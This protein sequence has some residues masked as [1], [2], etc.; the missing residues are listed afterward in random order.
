MGKRNDI[1][2]AVRNIKTWSERSEWSDQLAAVFDAHLS[3][4]GE[5]M[6]I[7][8]EDLHQAIVE[9]DY[10]G[11]LFGVMFEDFLSRRLS[12]RNNNIIDDYLERRGW[13]ESVAGR[14][15]L[16]QLRDSVLSIYEAVAVSPGKYC[17]LADLV[18]G[19]KVIRVYEH[20]GT[21]NMVKWDRIAAR[22][23]EMN[24]KHAFS[25]G[26][27]PFPHEASRD[28]LSLLSKLRKQFGKKHTRKR[29]KG[30]KTSLPSSDN[31]DDVLLR[32]ACPAFTSSWLV[33]ILKQSQRPLPAIVTRDGDSLV[34][35]ETRFPFLPEKAE[36]IAARLDAAAE[37]KRDSPQTDAWIWLPEPSTNVE[38]PRDGLA[39]NTSL[40]GQH[41]ISGTL[42]LKPGVL[43]LFTNSVELAERGTDVLEELLHNLIGPA[44]SLLQ[45]PE[46]LMASQPKQDN[47]QQREPTEN[48]DRKIEAEIIHHTLDQH[49]H[50][51]L[52][53]PIPALDNKTPRQCARNKTGRKKVIEWLKHL[54]NNE[55]RRAAEAGQE[56]YDSSWMWKELK[57]T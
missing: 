26:I 38:R 56:P 1:D 29:K 13:R 44:L 45:T 15:Y 5:L 25:G 37:W 11:M 51:C 8:M 17:E 28:L 43:A 10:G 40:E 34:F 55:L 14:R 42:E 2:K 18:R 7:S 30:A 39:F 48:I 33:H 21:Q 22:V 41:P 49:Y 6:D 16:Q 47:D 23:L 3:P 57:L 35:S 36:E 12:P 4:V 24:G 27:L 31:P 54:E 19:G 9:Y 46:Q 53:E 50:R 52:D 20:M 32:D